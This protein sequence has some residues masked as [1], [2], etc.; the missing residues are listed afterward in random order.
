MALKDGLYD[1]LI[2]NKLHHELT[3][4]SND[5]LSHLTALDHSILPDYLTRYL[6]NHITKA[7]RGLNSNETQYEL[8][9]KIIA[10]LGKR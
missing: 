3:Q 1:E 8:A 10:L 2:S 4:I 6:Q 9:N 5:Q 7:L